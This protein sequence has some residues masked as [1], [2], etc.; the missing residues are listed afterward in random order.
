MASD[1]AF[2]FLDK[3]AEFRQRIVAEGRPTFKLEMHYNCAYI[4]QL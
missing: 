4:E 2:Q 1:A 3:E